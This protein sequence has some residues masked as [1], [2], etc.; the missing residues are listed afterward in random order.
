MNRFNW[1]L[2]CS[3]GLVL[4]VGCAEGRI[5]QLTDLTWIGID[6]L[7]DIYQPLAGHLPDGTQVIPDIQ[8]WRKDRLQGLRDSWFKLTRDPRKHVL[9]ADGIMLPFRSVFDTVLLEEVLEHSTK[10]LELLKEASE[11]LR[12]SGRILITVPNEFKWDSVLKPFTHSGHVQFWDKE[13]F[14]E[15][16]ERSGLKI[17]F[18]W[19]SEP[20]WNGGFV[21]VYAICSK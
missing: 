21:F 4:E 1:T 5:G 8:K 17:R 2:N 15:L 7:Y 16:L 19:E 18:Y 13:S 12:E 11:V 6:N 9:L 10:P 3:R 20:Y 14:R